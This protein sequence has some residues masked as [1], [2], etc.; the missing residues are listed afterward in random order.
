M[1]NQD[2]NEEPEPPEPRANSD[3]YH[4]VCHAS[5]MI[6]TMWDKFIEE[7]LVSRQ[8]SDIASA[9][10]EIGQKLFDFYQLAAQKCM[11]K[12]KEEKGT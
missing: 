2:V 8:D 7:T 6:M 11:A 1:S 10:A 12:E 5:Y 3:R 4:E 9:A